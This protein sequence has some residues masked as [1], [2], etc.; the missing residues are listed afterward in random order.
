[1]DIS[2]A[3]KDIEKFCKERD[4]D[5]FPASLV[6]MHL[7][8]EISEIGEEILFEEGYKKEGA[9][10]EKSNADVSREFAQSLALLLQLALHF[11]VDVEKAFVRELEIME[12]RFSPEDWKKR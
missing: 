3:Q 12:Q 6:Y 7:I 8:E 5:K 2:Q 1:M 9:G 10:H 11:K 4:W